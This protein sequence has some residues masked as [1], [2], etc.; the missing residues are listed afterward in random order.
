M[1]FTCWM[2]FKT[3]WHGWP[4]C[5]HDI[6]AGCM[7]REEGLRDGCP[8]CLDEFVSQDAD[9]ELC[10]VGGGEGCGMSIGGMGVGSGMGSG[11]MG[12]GGMGRFLPQADP[13][14]AFDLPVLHYATIPPSDCATPHCPR[15]CKVQC[16]T[17]GLLDSY[18]AL[19]PHRSFQGAGITVMFVPRVDLRL[20]AQFMFVAQDGGEP[21]ATFC[22]PRNVQD[23]MAEKPRSP[24]RRSF[25]RRP[26]S[27]R[28]PL[29]APLSHRS[30]LYSSHPH[31]SNPSHSSHPSNPSHPSNSYL[32]LALAAERQRA[33]FHQVFTN[34]YRHGVPPPYA[35]SDN[36]ERMANG[37]LTLHVPLPGM[38]PAIE[39]VLRTLKPLSFCRITVCMFDAAS[40]PLGH[41]GKHRGWCEVSLRSLATDETA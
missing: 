37:D 5:N 7:H 34:L 1:P 14:L 15:C 8:F 10:M 18:T 28:P 13:P 3:V 41:G 23:C 19:T 21:R 30:K 11:G 24:L 31:S 20:D 33:A 40:V 2:C 6:C 35:Y 17:C 12:S 27:C 9:E 25:S 38:D 32:R 36:V 4:S 39:G 16:I 29:R 26:S 22:I